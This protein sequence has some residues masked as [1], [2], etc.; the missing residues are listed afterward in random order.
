MSKSM[1][2][3]DYKKKYSIEKRREESKKIRE[4]YDDRIPVI[5]CKNESSSVP[6]IDKQKYL[7]PADLTIAQFTYVIRKRIQLPA[8]QALWVFVDSSD[9]GK[10]VQVLPPTSNTMSQVYKEYVEDRNNEKDYDGFLYVV[11][12]GENVFGN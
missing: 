7:I 9:N 12:S 4:K 1:S 2:I 10:K 8:E 3:K 6:D 11:Y 5:V